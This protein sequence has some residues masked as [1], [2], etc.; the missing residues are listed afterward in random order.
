MPLKGSINPH[1]WKYK[2]N[3]NF[4]KKPNSQM[5]Y[6][7][8]FLMADGS[9]GPT[10][11][12]FVVGK[13]RDKLLLEKINR[14][15]ESDYPLKRR[16][17]GSFRLRIFNPIIIRDLKKLNIKFGKVKNNTLPNIPSCFL[18]DFIRGYLDG[19]GWITSDRKNM[20]ISVGFSS[21]N[22]KFLMSLIKKL[23]QKL[24]LKT[25]NLRKREKITKNN[26][27][28]TCYQLEYYSTN[29]YKIIK[30]LY[31]DLGKDDL[32]LPR[33]YQKQLKAREIYENLIK[34]T[35]L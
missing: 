12:S 21:G 25:N 27:I 4:F 17:D 6:I 20:E 33:K 8:G 2:I 32:F 23:N 18:R 10:A 3:V 22:R 14:V 34:G 30:Y 9:F 15:M 13:K 31:D 5:A 24:N 1:L 29:A 28:S 19:D 11:V 16:K 7:L 26:K 35:K